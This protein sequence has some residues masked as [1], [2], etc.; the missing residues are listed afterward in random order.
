MIYLSASFYFTKLLAVIS[1]NFLDIFSGEIT[2]VILGVGLGVN[3]IIVVLLIIFIESDISLFVA[4][5]FDILKSIPKIGG[6][7]AQYEEKIKHKIEKKKWAKTAEFYGLTL[8]AAIPF[9]GTGA[10]SS[11]LIGRLLGMEWKRSWLAVT[12]G[13]TLRSIVILTIIYFGYIT[14]T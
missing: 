10:L 9:Y 2:A 14:L 3:P 6:K 12:I 8:M 13:V 5:N 7:I 11:T 1:A 4:W